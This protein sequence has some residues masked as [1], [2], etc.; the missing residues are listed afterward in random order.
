M[1]EA[2][3]VSETFSSQPKE[4]EKIVFVWN[5]DKL[6]LSLEVEKY[7]SSSNSTYYVWQ[8]DSSLAFIKSL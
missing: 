1:L 8:N 7:C 5:G 6:C 4:R 3:G 2:V